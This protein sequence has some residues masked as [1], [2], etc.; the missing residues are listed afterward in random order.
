[1]QNGFTRSKLELRGPEN[2]FKF[3]PGRP[4]SGGSASS[5]ALNL[6]VTTKQAGGRAGG[7]AL[8]RALRPA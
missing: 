5:C 4:R 8:R 6:M 7:A 1:M 3:H 2:D